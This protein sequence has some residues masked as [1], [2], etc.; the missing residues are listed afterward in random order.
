MNPWAVVAH[1]IKENKNMNG[2]IEDIDEPG[3]ETCHLWKRSSDETVNVL[4]DGEVCLTCEWYRNA[5]CDQW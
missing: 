3:V 2:P 5:L 1:A 4:R